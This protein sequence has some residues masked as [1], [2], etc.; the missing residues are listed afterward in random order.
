MNLRGTT[1]RFFTPF[2]KEKK[3]E[4]MK[5]SEEYIYYG[6]GAYAAD[7]FNDFRAEYAPLCFCDRAAS[8]GGG[9]TLFGLPVLPPSA[10]LEEYPDASI[11]ITLHPQNKLKVQA[12]LL[13]DMKIPSSRIANFEPYEKVYSCSYIENDIYSHNDSWILCCSDYG[14]NVSP[15]VKFQAG[16]SAVEIVS[17]LKR[18]K[19]D[20]LK[21]I[22]DDTPCACT[23]CRNLKMVVRRLGSESPV[24]NINFIHT[25]PCNLKCQYCGGRGVRYQE[26]FN[27]DWELR[28]EIIEVL[29][30]QGLVKPHTAAFIGSGEITIHSK[31]REILETFSGMP[32][33]IAS[34]CVIYDEIVADFLVKE[35]AYLFCSVDAGTRETYAKIKGQD[36][37]DKLRNSLQ[38]YAQGGAA[39]EL[40]YIFLPGVN[41]NEDDVEGFTR[42]ASELKARKVILSRD[43]TNMTPL[44]E[45]TIDMM[46]KLFIHAS[47][48][49]IPAELLIPDVLSGDE[50]ERLMKR[51]SLYTQGFLKEKRARGC[52]RGE[53]FCMEAGS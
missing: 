41:D 16:A 12:W 14:R 19:H 48:M 11:V 10:M 33:M 47:D 35:N 28:R 2:K 38:K 36:L 4:I 50:N 22:Q 32:C 21:A 15:S 17:E 13:E 20:T 45:F 43:C 26:E 31:R 6:A 29:K 39:I 23:G 40:K 46:A 5:K 53:N 18:L 9:K 34:N 8:Q 42:L 30:Q 49:S 7:H 3:G 52:K 37:F 25:C 24:N 27:I 44:D 51:I 1:I